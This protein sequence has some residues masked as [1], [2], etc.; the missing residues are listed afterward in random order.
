MTK[1]ILLF[2]VNEKQKTTCLSS[3]FLIDDVNSKK[4]NGTRGG[5]GK[6]IS[7][8][9]W[10]KSHHEKKSQSFSLEQDS[11]ALSKPFQDFWWKKHKWKGMRR[12]FLSLSFCFTYVAW[13]HNA[14]QTWSE[15]WHLRVA[16]YQE[17]PQIWYS[18]W[19]GQLRWSRWLV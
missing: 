16:Q 14:K 10:E 7:T 4:E 6:H 5:F 12:V 18:D 15:A 19:I 8:F 9:L 2:V 11:A 13:V 1:T 3:E 17:I